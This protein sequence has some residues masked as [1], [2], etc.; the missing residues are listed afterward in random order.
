[1]FDALTIQRT[2]KK[3]WSVTDA[4][5]FIDENSGLH[6]DPSLVLIFHEVMPEILD[7]KEQY[8]ESTYNKP[9]QE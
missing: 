3:A 2:Y 1:M 6:F 9:N 8:G 4:V 5:K 7:I